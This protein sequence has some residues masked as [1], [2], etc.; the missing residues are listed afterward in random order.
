MAAIQFEDQKATSPLWA[1]KDVAQ[2]L[3]VT[4]RKVRSLIAEGELPHYKVGRVL[5]FRPEEV[6]AWLDGQRVEAT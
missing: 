5:R 6:G 3:G 4:E 1:V 2:F